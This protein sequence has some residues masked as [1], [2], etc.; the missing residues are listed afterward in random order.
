MH[1][2]EN[3]PNPERNRRAIQG[4]LDRIKTL[5]KSARG[6]LQ[7]MLD[8]EMDLPYLD[9]MERE[10]ARA[11]QRVAPDHAVILRGRFIQALTEQRGFLVGL[12]RKTLQD[13]DCND[14]RQL[15]QSAHFEA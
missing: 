12:V 10:Y 11:F 3:F 15:G 8:E 9:V 5:D 14:L 2:P 1:L 4:L 7:A 13:C 6:R